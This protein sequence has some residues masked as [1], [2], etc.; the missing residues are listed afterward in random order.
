M[1]R[2]AQTL[3][4]FSNYSK[5][6]L[7]HDPMVNVPSRKQAPNHK[8]DHLFSYLLQVS[9]KA[10]EPGRNISSEEQDTSLQGH[11]EDKQWVTFKRAGDGGFYGFFL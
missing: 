4:I 1:H 3:Q 2:L 9:T 5:I 8:F 10:F 6:N 11:H 7:V